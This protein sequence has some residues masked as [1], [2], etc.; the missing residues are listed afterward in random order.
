MVSRTGFEPVTVTELSDALGKDK[1]QIGNICSF[2][3]TEGKISSI[4]EP[5]TLSKAPQPPHSN[6]TPTHITNHSITKLFIWVTWFAT[7]VATLIAIDSMNEI[8][9]CYF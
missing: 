7:V 4:L 3:S 8:L 9:K 6:P 2:L 1:G 5:Y